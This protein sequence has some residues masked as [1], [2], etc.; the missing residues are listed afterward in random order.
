MN[1]LVLPTFIPEPSSLT[2]PFWDLA[3]RGVLSRQRC[4]QCDYQMFPPQFACRM[5]LDTSLAWVPSKGLGR[6]YSFSLLHVGIDGRALPQP[7]ILVD[8]DLE[9]GWNMLTNLINCPLDEVRCDMA[10]TVTWKRLSASINL[11]VFEPA[12]R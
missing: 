12:G 10:V 6:L 9:E 3:A 8:I 1:D 2:Q 11:P 4:K 7:I 5:C